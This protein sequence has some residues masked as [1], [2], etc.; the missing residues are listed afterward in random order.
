[1]VRKE[2][3]KA[4]VQRDVDAG[5][6]IPLPKLFF[7]SQTN[8]RPRASNFSTL[9][10]KLFSV[11]SLDAASS[12]G[13]RSS[14]VLLP[15]YI[16]CGSRTTSPSLCLLFPVSP[17]NSFFFFFHIFSFFKSC[18]AL[19]IHSRSAVIT[20]H[21]FPHRGLAWT[22]LSSITAFDARFFV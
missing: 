12:G 9:L 1:M 3:K 8:L 5:T 21:Y 4:P 2:K 14:R 22:G 6:N 17:T 16:Y 15:A 11:V 7:S 10:G 19:L 18:F 20:V 13:Q